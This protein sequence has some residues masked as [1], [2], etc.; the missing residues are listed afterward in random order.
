MPAG[1]PAAAVKTLS[2]ALLKAL[3]QPKVRERFA[4]GLHIRAEIEKWARIAKSA[5]IRAE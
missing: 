2:D 3:A 1:A 5:N 4:F